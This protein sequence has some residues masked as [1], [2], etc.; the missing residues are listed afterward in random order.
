MLLLYIVLCMECSPATIH[1]VGYCFIVWHY[2]S[3]YFGRAGLFVFVSLCIY[4]VIYIYIYIYDIIYY[5]KTVF[6]FIVYIIIGL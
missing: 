4:K 5:I 1:Y 6:Y 2:L 3:R